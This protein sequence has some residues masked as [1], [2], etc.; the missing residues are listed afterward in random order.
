MKRRFGCGMTLRYKTD[1]AT[2]AG[3]YASMRTGAGRQGWENVLLRDEK[4]E[5]EDGRR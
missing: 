5:P 2:Y 4:R 3:M 1:S